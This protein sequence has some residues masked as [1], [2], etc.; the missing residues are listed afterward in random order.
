M[1]IDKESVERIFYWTNGNPRMT[2]DLCSE[3]ENRAKQES[4]NSKLVDKVVTEMY[5]TEFDKPPVDNIRELVKKDR[6]IRNSIIDIEQK[7]TKSI[8]DK[9]KNKLYLSGIINYEDDGVQIKNNIIKE[10]LTAS[11]VKSLE[12]EEKGL[13]ETALSFVDKGN[14]SEGIK[15]FE[16]F[17]GASEFEDGQK[18]LC[19][20]YMAFAAYKITEFEK[21][22]QSQTYL[23]GHC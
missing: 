23:L 10:S 9:L 2:W 21:A 20:Y 14:Y 19:Y 18:G 6:E 8:S 11:W 15:T 3:I 13:F 5:L 16:K 17:L 7:K 4:I 12:L 1:D 22:L